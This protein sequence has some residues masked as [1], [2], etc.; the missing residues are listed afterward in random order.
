MALK[1][2]VI[3]VTGF[4]QNIPH[5]AVGRCD[6]GGGDGRSRR[7]CAARLAAALEKTGTK[8]KTIYLTHGHF[9]HA[10]GA[11]A[12][13]EHFDVPIEGPQREDSFWIDRIEA[14]GARYGMP[15]CRRFEP[16]RWRRR[17]YG[18]VPELRGPALPRPHARPC[19]V[20]A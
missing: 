5:L 1:I 15:E 8:L 11:A 17:R 10:G 20:R 6:A 9:D 7:Q 18:R 16:D 12:L 3:P 4:Q 14:S 19:R 2:G 13:A